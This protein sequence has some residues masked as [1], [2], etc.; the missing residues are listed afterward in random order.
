MKVILS[1]F[2]FAAFILNALTDVAM[3]DRTAL[4]PLIMG[5]FVLYV[6]CR[7]AAGKLPLRKAIILGTFGVGVIL[8]AFLVLAFMRGNTAAS[9]LA[10]SLLGY[11]VASYNRFAAVLHGQ[12]HYF[13]AGKGIYLITYVQN[14]PALDALNITNYLQWPTYLDIYHSEF[15]SLAL[16]GLNTHFNWSG[17]FGYIY[18]DIGWG[19]LIY[20]YLAGMFTGY[21][22]LKVKAG[23]SMAITLFP[24]VASWVCLWNTWNLIF[25]DDFVHLIPAAIAVFF[26]DKLLMV[27]EAAAEDASLGSFENSL[28]LKPV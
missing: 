17:V 2:W 16:A 18:A 9:L 4:I 8:A 15:A 10:S 28:E 20:L 1:V 11:S 6:Y 26:W 21:M 12:L 3:L 14:A 23:S 5:T 13:Y 25:N 7:E 27:Q 22:W 19:A 24:W